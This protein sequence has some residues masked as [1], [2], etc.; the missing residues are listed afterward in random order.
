MLNRAGWRTLAGLGA[1]LIAPGL[2]V[3]HPG[4]PLAVEPEIV[5]GWMLLTSCLTAGL[6]ALDKARAV[7]GGWRVPERTLHLLELAG[8]WPGSWLA[9]GMLRHKT[10]KP[11]YRRIFALIVLLH[12]AAAVTCLLTGR[13]A[14]LRPQR[15]VTWVRKKEG[16]GCES[17]STWTRVWLLPNTLV[18]PA[19][20]CHDPE[21]ALV[22]DSSEYTRT[23]PS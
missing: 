12:Q 9:R 3:F 8:G 7:R 11:G 17:G 2:V 21:A 13:P 22:L 10:V 6:H 4:R 18:N 20:G 1:L 14:T 19:T 5:C 15:V 23:L 16:A